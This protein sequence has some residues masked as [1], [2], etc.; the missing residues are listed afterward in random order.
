MDVCKRSRLAV[1]LLASI[2]MLSLS[3]V[4]LLVRTAQAAGEVF[5]APASQP[6]LPIG[7]TFDVQVNVS[8]IEDR[9]SVV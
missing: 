6:S 8:S 5:V 7:S 1:L 4:P 9:K 2:M 3:A